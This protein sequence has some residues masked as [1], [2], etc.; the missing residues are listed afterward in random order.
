LEN[1][2]AGNVEFSGDIDTS[3]G[4]GANGGYA[5]LFSWEGNLNTGAFTV[6]GGTGEGADYHGDDGAAYVDGANVTP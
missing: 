1:L 5:I 2:P 3:G 4:D 6:T